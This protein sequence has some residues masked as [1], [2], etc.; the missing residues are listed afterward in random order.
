MMALTA[1]ATRKSRDIIMKTLGMHSTESK[2]ISICPCKQNIYYSVSDFKSVEDSFNSIALD[3]IEKS[4]CADRTIIFCQSIADCG[5]LYLYFKNKL[6]VSFLHPTGAPNKSK[7][8]LVEAF[9]SLLEPCH[10]EKIVSSFCS[11]TSPLRLVIATIAFG[12]GINCPNV[13]KIIHYGAPEDL[14]TYIQETGRAG[15]DGQHASALII[16]R[17]RCARIT[18]DMAGY[19]KLKDQS[20]RRDYLFKD[21]DD[22]TNKVNSLCMCCDLCKSTCKCTKCSVCT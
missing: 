16:C 6:G 21:Y 7:Y 4:V 8:R 10:K 12:M 11:L 2:V 13:R 1:T 3:L 14:D 22:Y 17:K 18:D 5:D 20:C 19:L 9:H 15:R